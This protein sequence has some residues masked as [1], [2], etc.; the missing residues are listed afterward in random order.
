[1]QAVMDE[2]LDLDSPGLSLKKSLSE[3]VGKGETCPGSRE[4]AENLDL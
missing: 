2:N 3:V 1:M 4:M